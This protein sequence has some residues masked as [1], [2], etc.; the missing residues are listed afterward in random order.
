MSAAGLLLGIF[1]VVQ[2]SG[3]PAPPQR[4]ARPTP[5]DGAGV[6]AGQVLAADTGLPLRRAVVHLGGSQHGRSVQ[7]DADGRYAV[8][9]L[10]PG[11]YTVMVTAGP[12]RANYLSMSYGATLP[13]GST[14]WL[15]SSSKSIKLDAGQILDN[16]NIGLPRAA[17]ISGHVVDGF[18]EPVARVHVR[19]LRVQRGQP[20]SQTEA[21]AT[22]DDLGHYRLFGLA[23]GDYVVSV[24]GSQGDMGVNDGEASGFGVTYAP[25]TGNLAQ[26][27]RIRLVAGAV[28]TA[29]LQLVETRLFTITGFVMTSGGEPPRNAGVSATRADT[30][31]DG[32]I[33]GSS[34]SSDGAFTI[35]NVAP[36]TYD[37]HVRHSPE[38]AKPMS[39]ELAML[40]VEVMGDLEGVVLAT[41]PGETVEGEIV[42]DDGVSE[43]RRVFLSAPTRRRM[44][45]ASPAIEVNGTRFTMRGVF[46]PVL[47]R[48]GV[49]A[50]GTNLWLKTVLLDGRDVT[51]VPT[52][53]TSRDSGR[54][55]VIFTSRASMLDG[56]VT[57]E[58]GV[59][60]EECTVI[61][62]NEDQ[63]TWIPRSLSIRTTRP[64]NK[65]RFVLPGLREGRYRVVALPV[66]MH[67]SM[68][69]PDVELLE[70]LNKVAIPVLV[71]AGETRTVDLRV[72]RFDQ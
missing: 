9:K 7:T 2:V 1:F 28:A 4:D 38:P 22:T 3:V 15:H 51:E 29:D 62:F 41:R 24:A 43:G 60:V 19:A 21:G 34:V 32:P 65:G 27:T 70:A 11:T 6:I 26:A 42:F 52:A 5:P 16:I 47:L 53:F 45:S 66:E 37:L 30:E 13:H 54:L 20:M 14:F 56:Q 72:V 68:D 39:Y 36:G 71:N 35:R 31:H 58:A 44:F 18:G 57:D 64:S 8:T 23:P 12:H 17:A 49:Q 61:A 25:G 33:F 50:S 46:S 48:G 10:P 40:R 59:A 63:A 67:V 55:Q 69:Q